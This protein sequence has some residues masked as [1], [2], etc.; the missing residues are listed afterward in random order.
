MVAHNVAYER[1]NANSSAAFN[2]IDFSM[3]GRSRDYLEKYLEAVANDVSVSSVVA[4][5]KKY[6]LPLFDNNKSMAFIACH[7]SMTEDV[8]EKFEK[9][10][11]KSKL[12]RWK[13]LQEAKKM[14]KVMW[15]KMRTNA[16]S[17]R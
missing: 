1:Q 7:S 14:T 15:K 10:D 11:I 9:M 3:K 6:L 5:M 13:K 2:Y 4:V 17:Y 12:K 16:Y 8:K